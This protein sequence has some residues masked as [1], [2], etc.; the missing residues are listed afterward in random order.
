MAK[1][2]VL[3]S[4]LTATVTATGR[5]PVAAVDSRGISRGPK[6]LLR[7]VLPSNRSGIR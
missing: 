2:T 5:S 7:I 4:A 6:P 3:A 1:G